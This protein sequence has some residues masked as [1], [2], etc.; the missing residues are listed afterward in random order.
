MG[1]TGHGAAFGETDVGFGDAEGGFVVAAALVEAGERLVG[2]AAD[3][4]FGDALFVE[5]Y[6]GVR[7]SAPVCLHR[8][9]VAFDSGFVAAQ[10]VLFGPD[11]LLLFRGQ[12]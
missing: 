4:P 1:S 5:A 8:L 12:G 3:E 2:V 7:V 10:G 11:L 9:F 6:R